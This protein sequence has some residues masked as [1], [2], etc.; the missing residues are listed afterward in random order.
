VTYQPADNTDV[1]IQIRTNEIT[2]TGRN[3]LPYYFNGVPYT[4]F[5]IHTAK[6]KYN[7]VVLNENAQGLPPE[8]VLLE[9]KR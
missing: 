9:L 2:D 7:F 4:A 1:P 8:T 3:K 6:K 5:H